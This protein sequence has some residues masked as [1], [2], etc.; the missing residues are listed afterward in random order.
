MSAVAVCPTGDHV[1]VA[2]FSDHGVSV[3]RVDA[4]TGRL[5]FVDMEQDGRAGV[6][7]LLGPTS[8]AL[9]PDGTHLYVA[10]S[11][12]DSIAIF[13][14][15][16]VAGTLTY[17][18]M[19]EDG[20]GGVSGL[21]DV[22]SVAV[23]PGGAHVYAASDMGDAVAVFSRDPDSGLLT[24]VEAH[25]DG[26]DG[27]D[28]L[29]G[30]CSVSVSPDGKHVYVASKDDGAVAIFERDGTTGSLT[31]VDRVTSAMCTELEYAS[32]VLVGP[33]GSQVYVA[34]KWPGALV[35][36]SRNATT[37]ALTLIGAA[38]DGVGGVDG[39]AG[40]RSLAITGDGSRV[41]VAGFN[42]S[43]LAVFGRNTSTGAL[44]YLETE[45]DG[46]GA[47]DGLGGATA[48]ASN[49]TKGYV[50]AAG[51]DDSAVAVF[52]REPDGALSFLQARSSVDGLEGAV[53]IAVSPDGEQVYVAGNDDDAVVV[54][55]RDAATGSLSYVQTKRDAGGLADGLAGAR[56]VVVSPDGANVYVAG[57]DDN[58]VSMPSRNPA[59]GALTNLGMV[60]DGVGGV[61][62]L[63]GPQGLALSPGGEHLYVASEAEDAVAI[64]RRDG[65]SGTLSYAGVVRRSNTGDVAL[66]G[67]YAVA[68]SPDGK[69]V[70]VPGCYDDTVALFT[71]NSTTGLLTYVGRLTDG[72]AGIDGLNGA[73]SVAISPDGASVYVA[74]REDDA[75]AIFS[76]NEA[77]GALTYLGMVKDGVGG[78]D[79][80]DG[81]RAVVVSPD[82]S[83]VYVASQLDDALAVFAR[84][85]GTGLLT[86]VKAHK[87]GQGGVDGL[88]TADGLAV[89]P[90]GAHIYVAGY[91]DDAVAVFARNVIFL[92]LVLRGG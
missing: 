37:G 48:V 35:A 89:S 16:I 58:A 28:G 27:V 40:A 85:P 6:D 60:Q 26:A 38:R 25:F 1:Y 56:A 19:V 17:V 80:L 49:P 34:S 10:S 53:G 87:D 82:G 9:S 23:S 44:T 66:D 45:W 91:G 13:G 73:N 29:Q 71:R 5:E 2:G 31:Y 62:G 79:G 54:F 41:Y 81:A 76:R 78:V 11:L 68:I 75:V 77:N 22:E 14:R 20:V 30:A 46:A 43:A 59:N 90:D 18:G 52:A 51:Y 61:D 69:H 4:T 72:F 12:D 36:F 33:G 7:G 83:Q 57:H 88:N 3:F 67:A 39:L 47:V 32:C 70:Y 86:F 50:Y 74:G 24:F 15:A 84:D 21:D 65:I 92:P 64:F 55:A 63:G 8:I 42:D